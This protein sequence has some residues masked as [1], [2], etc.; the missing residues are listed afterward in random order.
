MVPIFT[1]VILVCASSLAGMSLAWFI[2]SSNSSKEAYVSVAEYSVTKVTSELMEEQLQTLSLDIDDIDTN[3]SEVCSY[4]VQIDLSSKANQGYCVVSITDVEEG[5][6]IKKLYTDQIAEDSFEFYL[7]NVPKEKELKI[8][9]EAFW[10]IAPSEE[11]LALEDIFDFSKE[12]KSEASE[13]SSESSEA[14]IESSEA[15]TESSENSEAS[16]ESS[17]DSEAST[18][19]S[20]DSEASTESSEDSEASTESSES[21][22]GSEA[23]TESSESSEASTES[24]DDSEAST[25]S[26]ESSEASTES[27]E[28]SE[29][30]T[31]SSESSEDEENSE[32][33]EV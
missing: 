22:E 25:E 33:E 8:E 18:E 4:R 27:S 32:S 19:S 23:S 9:A 16:I 15:I 11:N 30:S 14:S 26:S 20:E 17:E 3:S 2:D 21:S 13:M 10:G 28:S 1:L 24:S 5:V 12:V 6:E 31:E 7:S 29:A